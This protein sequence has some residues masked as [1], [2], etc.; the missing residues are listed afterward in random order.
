MYKSTG[1]EIT[2]KDNSCIFCLYSKIISSLYQNV[3]HHEII[4]IQ[5]PC[6]WRMQPD[7]DVLHHHITTLHITID[8]QTDCQINMGMP[9]N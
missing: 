2:V 6:M 8:T 3:N 5:Y 4:S 7:I 1:F 9:H